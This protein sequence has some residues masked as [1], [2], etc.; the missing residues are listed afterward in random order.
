[1]EVLILII[2]SILP[3]FLL[4]NYIYNKDK[5]KEPTKLLTKLFLGGIASCVLSIIVAILLYF[6]FPI[7]LEEPG[8]LNWIEL[9]IYSF[10]GV[11]LVEEM[12]KWIFCYK[13]AYNHIEFDEIYDMIVYSSF[14]ALGFACFENILY[15][16]EGGVSVGIAR[17]VTAVPAHACF[18]VF[19]GYYLAISKLNY[20]NNNL[21]LQRKQVIKS[22]LIPIIMHGIYDYCLFSR[23][24]ILILLLIFLI[25]IIYIKTISNIKK[26]SSV[27]NKLKYKD[28]Y[29]PICGTVVKSNF[30]HKCG[31]KNE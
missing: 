8:N 1:M 23:N 6:T 16:L 12:C 7:I 24:V 15:V 10:I 31:R 27:T 14:V 26:L 5:N 21:T 11:S 18:G 20:I 28:N 13:M 22:I 29:C 30:C 2:I 25:I 19:M 3:V 17:A 9:I 4:G